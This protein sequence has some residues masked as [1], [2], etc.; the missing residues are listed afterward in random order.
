MYKLT[1]S[2]GDIE[3]KV[4]T[5]DTLKEVYD[6][7]VKEKHPLFATAFRL[8]EWDGGYKVQYQIETDFWYDS[9]VWRL[10]KV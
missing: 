5:L 3:P 9:S 7:V 4:W 2:V 1:Y 6:V 10:E 8:S